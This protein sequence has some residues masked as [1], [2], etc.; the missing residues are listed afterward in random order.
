MLE[1]RGG[2][3]SSGSVSDSQNREWNNQRSVAVAVVVAVV[4]VV[5]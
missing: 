2:L 4:V 5:R 3:W 1:P